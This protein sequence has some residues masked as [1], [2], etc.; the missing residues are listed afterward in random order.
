MNLALQPQERAQADYN[1]NLWQFE[2]DMDYVGWQQWQSRMEYSILA[3]CQV[4][5]FFVA[6]AV[7]LQNAIDRECD[8]LIHRSRKIFTDIPRGI[9][10]AAF[11]SLWDLLEAKQKASPSYISAHY[12][13]SE[14]QI[15]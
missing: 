8:G 2:E 1:T 11:V 4:D 12:P 5:I 6:C 10:H 3:A 13:Y 15:L 7:S 9:L 14:G